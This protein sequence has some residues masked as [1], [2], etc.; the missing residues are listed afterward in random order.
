MKRL[1]I[2]IA[3]L[4]C[5]GGLLAG[6]VSLYVF[7][8]S[9]SEDGGGGG[10]DGPSGCFHGGHHPA[11]P[12]ALEAFLNEEWQLYRHGQVDERHLCQAYQAHI[13][14]IQALHETAAAHDTPES[15]EMLMVT[16][17]LLEE[18]RVT[19]VGTTTDTPGLT[20]ATW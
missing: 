8:V 18:Q 1:M 10:G 17:L 5:L 15:H 6:A 9:A 11:L 2:G 20:P 19:C 13:H 3:V 7:P 14:T 16:T 4:W 12:P